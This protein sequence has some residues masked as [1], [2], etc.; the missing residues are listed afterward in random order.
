MNE[1]ISLQKGPVVLLV[2]DDTSDVQLVEAA[3]KRTPGTINLIR[4]G[5]GDDAVNY[6]AGNTP[7]D[8]RAKYPLPL[9]MLL[10]IKLPKRSGFEVLQWLRNQH[11]PV[12]RLPTVILTSSKHRQ[13]IDRAFDQG[14]NAYVAKPNSLKE[15]AALL[16]EFKNFWLGRLEFP[17]VRAPQGI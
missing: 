11:G 9:T 1:Q 15:L 8:N 6:L 2:E 5:D 3:L 17:D 4:V 12:K 13:D 7:Y 14:A 16:G 10:D